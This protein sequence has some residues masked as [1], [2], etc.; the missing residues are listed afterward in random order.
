MNSP[1]DKL[2]V[3]LGRSAWSRFIEV[4]RTHRD[5]GRALPA[6]LSLTAPTDEE[7][8]AH[9]QLLRLTTLSRAPRLRY[10]LTAIADALQRAGATSGWPDILELLCGPIPLST[11]ATQAATVAWTALWLTQRAQ[12]DAAPFPAHIDWLEA[13][14]RDGAL[15]RLAAGD[16]DT[17]NHLLQQAVVLLRALPLS[18]DQPLAH[19]A[20]HYGGDSHALDLDQP[21]ANLVL[22]GLAL[23]TNHPLPQRTEERRALWAEFGVVCD[24]LS[25][26]VLTF[27]LGITGDAALAHLVTQ[28]T[29]AVQPL[30]LSTRLLWSTSWKSLTCPSQVFIF[31]NPTMIALAAT[32]LGSACPPLVCVDGEPKT[33]ARLLLRALSEGGTKLH[34]HGDFDWGGMAIAGRVLRD[35]GATPWYFDADAYLAAG[36]KIGRSL[37]GSPVTTPW[38]TSLHQL[39]IDTGKAYD[40]EALADDLLVNLSTGTT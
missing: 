32:R 10:E 30:H 27:N 14:R 25:A 9:A 18:T 37:Q 33:A 35:F 22:R 12:L 2:R 8:R 29:A 5:A 38:S 21:L 16:A 17:A 28:A 36:T 23:R 19:V 31:E 6:S 3:I 40:E 4:L 7:R 20:A 11:L 1:S 15:K 13:L 39:M 34:Y 24:E 26:P